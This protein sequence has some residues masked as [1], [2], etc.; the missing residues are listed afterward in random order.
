LIDVHCG[1]IKKTDDLLQA[2]GRVSS[3]EMVN[4]RLDSPRCVSSTI[5]TMPLYMYGTAV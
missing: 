1:S 3:N 4:Q 2:T 5:F